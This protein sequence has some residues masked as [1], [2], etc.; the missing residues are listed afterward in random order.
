MRRFARYALW[1]CIGAPALLSAQGFGVY[2]H[3]T[4]TMGRS[5]TA[6]ASPCNDGSAIFFNPAGLAS[7]TGTRAS[8]G[9]T[10]ILPSGG[11]TRDITGTTTDAPS[12][13]YLVPN[14]FLSH[15]LNENTG[16]GIGVYAPYGL[17][18]K[19]PNDQ[20][21]E[22][23]FLGYKTL[24]KS[25]Y[26]Q[27]TI[28]YQLSDRLKLGIGLAYIHSTVELHQRADLSTQPVPGQ[29]FTFA[30]LGIPAY[31]DFADAALDASGNGWAINFGAILKLSD[32]L[33]IGGHWLTRST[34]EYEGD[35][36]FEPVATGLTLPA[37]N[38]LSLPAGTPVDNL[39]APQFLPGAALSDGPATTEITMPPQGSLGLAWKANDQW[40]FLADY[41]L[42]VW[43]WF[44]AISLDFAN[45]GTPDLTLYEGY[46]DTH[47]FRFGTEYQYSPKLTFRGGYLY[48]TAA[49][50][51]QTVTPLLPEG[52]RNEFTLGLGVNLNDNLHA[53]FGYQYILQNDR[54]GRVHDASIGNT[55]L[56]TFTAHL[57]GAGLVYTF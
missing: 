45:A 3:G 40:T 9:G 32:Q 4:C 54:R 49:A 7:I 21:F 57:L 17:G 39:V 13:S 5:G 20:S 6:A 2:E 51:I 53:D 33:S 38:P 10:L 46:K 30:A 36:N 23:R 47:G 24:L 31:T 35:A 19:W 14:V 56:Y 18:T 55:G 42:V 43:G 25:I 27:P 15:R 52:A 11:F 29:A 12:Q 41:Q 34:I 28:G 37:G 50:P 1:W 26:V 22:G 16:V 8:L 48:H 44:A